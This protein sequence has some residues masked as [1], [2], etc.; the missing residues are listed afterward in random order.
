MQEYC[1]NYELYYNTQAENVIFLYFFPPFNLIYSKTPLSSLREKCNFYH[2]L[3]ASFPS[4]HE[5]RIL[6]LNCYGKGQVLHV[7][8]HQCMKHWLQLSSRHWCSKRPLPT[9]FC[10]VEAHLTA[11]ST[12][13]LGPY[14]K[15]HLPPGDMHN[16]YYDQC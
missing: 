13:V 6:D 8:I 12:S 1:K 14:L 3:G 2:Y 7:A 11:L 16:P 5:T 4:F 10:K 9:G 15:L